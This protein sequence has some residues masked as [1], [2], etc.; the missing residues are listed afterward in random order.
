MIDRM[1]RP[2]RRVAASL[3]GGGLAVAFLAATTML[4]S[5]AGATSVT[6][7]GTASVAIGFSGFD[8][9]VP[10]TSTFT[11]SFDPATG[12]LT[13][14]VADV[15]IDLALP[16]SGD[17]YGL[18]GRL[19]NP[20]AFTGSMSGTTVTLTGTARFALTGATIPG[21]DP[22][23]TGAL[24]LLGCNLDFEPTFTGTY[25]AAAETIT[26]TDTA[27]T[28]PRFPSLCA[29]ALDT[30]LGSLGADLH[31]NELLGQL[32]P[33][34]ATMTLAFDA[35][36]VTTTTNAPVDTS[37]APTNSVAPTAPTT[38]PDPTVTLAPGST[39]APTTT[40][41][42]HPRPTAADHRASPERSS[43]TPSRRHARAASAVRATPSYTG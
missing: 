28:V 14:E 16:I 34:S 7:G 1:N 18:T 32:P 29:V 8:L 2:R 39:A 27:I 37:D 38:S 31:V 25:D 26:V 20:T 30:L 11:G 43:H 5:S 40:A 13:A 19:S 41:A 33:G 21:I 15:P 17:T 6:T 22:A 9:P 42:S 4:P 36:L 12:T 23:L 24:G 35:P 3:V 10:Q